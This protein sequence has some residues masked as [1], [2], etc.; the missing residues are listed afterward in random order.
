MNSRVG[1]VVA[2][3]LCLV[4]LLSICIGSASAEDRFEIRNGIYLGDTFEEVLEKNELGFEIDDYANYEEDDN[5]EYYIW[6]N[7]GKIAGYEDT[8]MR[9]TFKDKILVDVVYLF[10]SKS[11]KNSVDSQYE[12]LKSSLTRKYGNP[13]GNTGGSLYIMTSGAFEYAL[14]STYVYKNL[15]DGIGDVRDYDEWTYTDLSAYNVKVDLVST[16]Y[17]K[18]YSDISFVNVIGYSIYTDEDIAG[19]VADKIAENDER[20]SD[21]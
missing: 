19:A 12:T 15:L 10:A 1:S 7:K 6:T 2:T 3:T 5:G 20:D 18:S 16:Y 11:E 4:L 9:F 17:G 21:L 13:L 14:L 8:K